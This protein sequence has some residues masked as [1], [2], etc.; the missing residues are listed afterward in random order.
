MDDNLPAQCHPKLSG[1]ERYSELDSKIT[2][3]SIPMND[4][5]EYFKTKCVICGHQRIMHDESG[6]CYGVMNK[7]CSSGCDSFKPE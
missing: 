7:P 1:K 5:F 4:L 2:G 6:K 3:L